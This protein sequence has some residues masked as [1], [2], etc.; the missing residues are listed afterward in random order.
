MTTDGRAGGDTL[1]RPATA[2]VSIGEQSAELPIVRGTE[3]D[4]AVDIGELRS[5]TGLVTLDPG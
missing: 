2:S 3:G 4:D 1:T 5:D